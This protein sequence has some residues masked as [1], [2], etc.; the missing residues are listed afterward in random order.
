MCV[1]HTHTHTAVDMAA[2]DVVDIETKAVELTV[3][4]DDALNTCVL[5]NQVRIT[6]RTYNWSERPR[7]KDRERH[8]WTDSEQTVSVY[9]CDACH[10]YNREKHLVGWDWWDAI[11]GLE[12]PTWNY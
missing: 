6:L 10:D 1:T 12:T 11:D 2:E 3:D 8:G 7:A 9:L 4:T 5:C